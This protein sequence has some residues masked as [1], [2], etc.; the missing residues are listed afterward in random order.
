VP[1][2]INRCPGCGEPVS[3]FAAGCAICGHDLIAAR[4]ALAQ[5]RQRVPAPFRARSLPRLGDDGLV[6]A[7]GLLLAIGSPLLGVVFGALMAWSADNDGL[8]RRR[9]MMFGVI[10]VGGIQVAAGYWFFSP[11]LLGV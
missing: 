5:R 2:A 10:L 1:K 7:V 9:N 6:L 4:N 8:T 3:P 11:L